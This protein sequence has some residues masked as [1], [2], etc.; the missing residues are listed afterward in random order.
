M[1]VRHKIIPQHAEVPPNTEAKRIIAYFWG[2][3]PLNL[4]TCYCR[5]NET[6]DSLSAVG[7]LLAI[8]SLRYF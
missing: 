2:C 5:M 3:Y 8:I 7:R 6:S 4:T 1:M